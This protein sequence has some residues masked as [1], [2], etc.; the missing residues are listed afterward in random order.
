M[1]EARDQGTPERKSV[2]ITINIVVKDVNDNTPTFPNAV[3]DLV[4]PETQPLGNLHQLIATDLDIGNNKDLL[5]K[6]DL[7]QRGWKNLP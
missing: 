7:S 5:Y 4:Y 1:A 2:P 6:T 3:I